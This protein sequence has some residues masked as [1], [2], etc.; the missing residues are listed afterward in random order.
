MR[1][2]FF[3]FQPFLRFFLSNFLSSE[4]FWVK[5][6][7]FKSQ[8]KVSERFE[9]IKGTFFKL[10]FMEQNANLLFLCVTACDRRKIFSQR[11]HLDKE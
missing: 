9:E 5:K 8:Q 4:S 10:S 3:K 2:N 1:R 7:T 6:D 11:N